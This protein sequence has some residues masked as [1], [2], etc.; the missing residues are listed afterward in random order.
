MYTQTAKR[1]YETS[2]VSLAGQIDGISAAADAVPAASA[3]RV[4][5]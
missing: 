5:A 4:G 2:F 3:R 1:V